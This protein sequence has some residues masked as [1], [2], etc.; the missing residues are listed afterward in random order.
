MI[1]ENFDPNFKGDLLDMA[2]RQLDLDAAV[3]LE[4]AK[5]IEQMKVM[6]GS[7][8]Q[9]RDYTNFIIAAG[10]AAFFALWA[11]MAKDVAASER[12]MSGGLIGV[13][14]ISFIAWELVKAVSVMGE[15]TI[16]SSAIWSATSRSD[17]ASKV[18]N[19]EREI[20]S[21]DLM[22]HAFWPISF[23]ISVLTGLLGASVL[24][25]AALSRAFS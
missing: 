21:R 23:G 9:G 24:T 10:Y 1:D 2:K 15:G 22:L 17:L 20:I 25:I 16:L 18:E 11:G 12:L 4:E 6:A 14:L 19:A 7:F 8:R 3:L 13:S 5:A